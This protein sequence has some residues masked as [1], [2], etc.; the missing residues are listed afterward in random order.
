MSDII[1][2]QDLDQVAGGASY[3]GHANGPYVNYGSYVIYTVVPGDW[4]ISIG[5]R[6]GVSWQQIAQ[7]NNLRNPD[8]IE[9]GQKLTIYPTVIR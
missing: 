7:W 2:D 3:A 1:H 8:R 4:L 5:E 6:F 9:I